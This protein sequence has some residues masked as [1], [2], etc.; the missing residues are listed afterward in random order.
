YHMSRHSYASLLTLSQGVPMETVS[1]MLGH[2]SIKT[3]QIYAKIC[4]DK[5]DDDMRKLAKRIEGK[6]YLADL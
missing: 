5:I 3:T 6:Y 1:K 4:N 2:S